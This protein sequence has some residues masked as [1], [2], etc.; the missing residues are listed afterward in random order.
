MVKLNKA[1]KYGL[2]ITFSERGKFS[3]KKWLFGRSHTR[4]HSFLVLK[5]S[6]NVFSGRIFSYLYIVNKTD[7]LKFFNP[8][9][10]LS[11]LYFAKKDV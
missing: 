6:Y 5:T 10:L 7:S 9:L 8:L 1:K 4:G 11:Q 3:S 2:S